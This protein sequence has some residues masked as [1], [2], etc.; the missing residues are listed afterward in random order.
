MYGSDTSQAAALAATG[1]A[2]SVGW[3]VIGAGVLVLAGV[4]LITIVS[5]LRH[6]AKKAE[7]TVL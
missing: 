2:M 6:R 1:T 3:A 4:T 7:R 5:V